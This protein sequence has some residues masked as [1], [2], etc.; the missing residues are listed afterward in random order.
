MFGK[1]EIK[2]GVEIDN[3]IGFSSIAGQ[4][5]DV[6]NQKKIIKANSLI[7]WFFLNVVFLIIA[8][9]VFYLQVLKGAYYKNIA[10]NNRIKNVEVKAPRGLIIDRNGEILASNIPSFDLVFI[11]SELPVNYQDRKKIYSSLAIE[12]GLEKMKIENIIEGVDRK[13]QKKYLIK[14]G[15]DYDKALVLIEKLQNLSGI[16]LQKT[17]RRKYEKGEIISSV[18][19]YTGK[20]TEQELKAK[21]SYSINDYIGKNGLEYYYENWL[22]GQS[23]QVRTE[24][25]SSGVVKKELGIKPPISGNKLVLNI[26]YNLQRKSFAVLQNILEVN[27]EAK[28]AA[29]VAIDPRD[30]S[31]LAL[32]SLP[33]YDNNLFADGITTEEYQGFLSNPFNPLTNRVISGEYPPGSIYKPFLAA[34]GLEEGVINENT[35][36]NCTGSI[37]VGAWSFGDWKTHGITDLNKAIAESCNVYFYAVGGGWNNISGLGIDRMSKYSRYFGLG[38]LTQIDIPSEA[39]GTV[40]DAEWKFKEIGDRWYIGDSYHMSIGQGF[41]AVT[42]LQ[43]ALATSAIANEGTLYQPEIVDKIVSPTGQEQEIEKKIIRDNFISKD[44]F[45]KVKTAMRE[46]VVRGSGVSLN[47]MKVAVSGKTGTAQFGAEDKTHAWF[48]SFAPFDNPE[49]AMVVLVESGGEGHDWAV[50]ATEQI[51]REY[52]KEESE[53]IDWSEIERRVKARN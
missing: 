27:K 32:V 33:S 35:T 41:T 22:K 5:E 44:N 34:M 17:V 23:G 15:I 42:P 47:D 28:G 6:N 1:K 7:V 21:S 45:K 26:D 46:T 10:E 12:N 30:G 43:M 49:I 14:E 38:D 40:P 4:S 51:L 18:L 8:G 53:E 36:L 13:I 2:T 29:M 48:T 31:V 37:S 11:P 52:F 9:R 3:P 16:Y 24:V 19:G 25:D 39:T 20:I 50:P